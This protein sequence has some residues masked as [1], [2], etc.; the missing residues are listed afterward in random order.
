MNSPV[1]SLSRRVL[2]TCACL[3]SAV[4]LLA[5][6]T[7]GWAQ[8]PAAEQKPVVASTPKPTP[9][10][11]PAWYAKLE[12]LQFEKDGYTLPYRFLKPDQIDQGKVYPLVLFLHG[13]GECGT[14]NTRQLGNS[15]GE[16]IKRASTKEPFFMVVPQSKGWWVSVPWGLDSH[17]M[18]EKPTPSMDA[19]VALLGKITK[20]FPVDTKRIYVMGLSMGGLGTWDIISRY[21]DTF[22][23]A[24]PVC[25][26]GDTAQAPKLVNIPIWAFHGDRD[27]V[28]K[29]QRSRD[30]IEAIRKAGGNPKYTEIFNINHGAW[31]PAFTAPELYDWLFSQSKK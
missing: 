30:M 31:G 10:P 1:Y 13:V 4:L 12:A 25:G 7:S 27:T 20:E 8:Q 18:P 16:I 24:I 14:D 9:A 21:P 29:T 3:A 6:P 23:A 19:T 26:A 11:E 17:I 15:V 22:A 28:V 2:E 5:M